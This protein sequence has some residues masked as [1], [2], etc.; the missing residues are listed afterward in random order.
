MVFCSIFGPFHMHS[1]MFCNVLRCFIMF[2]V[3]RG[4]CGNLTSTCMWWFFRCFVVFMAFYGIL[5]CFGV[6]SGDFTC[7][8]VTFVLFCGILWCSAVFRQ[9]PTVACTACS[10]LSHPSLEK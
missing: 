8:Q 3:F 6:T 1:H 2:A 5:W 10:H 7:I 9:T 4:N